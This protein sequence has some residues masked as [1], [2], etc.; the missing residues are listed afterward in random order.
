M[1]MKFRGWSALFFSLILA[2]GVLQPGA[3]TAAISVGAPPGHAAATPPGPW[4]SKATK[5][6]AAVVQPMAVPPN[7]DAVVADS[8]VYPG[9]ITLGVYP[10]I[11]SGTTAAS[12]QAF[13][14]LVYDT[15]GTL[16]YSQVVPKST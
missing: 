7:P 9:A 10:H 2:V 15:T 13:A 5:N 8:F 4:S 3:A 1:D 6:G 12:L 14:V 16:V 11:P